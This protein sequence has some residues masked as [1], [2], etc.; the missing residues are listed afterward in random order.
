MSC[1]CLQ[2]LLRL[3]KNSQ[4]QN[5]TDNHSFFSMNPTPQPATS[6]TVPVYSYVPAVFQGSAPPPSKIY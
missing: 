6:R 4:H 3:Q 1:L 2:I 5:L